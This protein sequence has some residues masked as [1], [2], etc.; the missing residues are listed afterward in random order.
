MMVT[1]AFCG[2][3]VWWHRVRYNVTR[4]VLLLAITEAKKTTQTAAMEVHLGLPPFHVMIKAKAKAQA[5]IYRLMCNHQPK[6]KGTDF[7]HIKKILG[8]EHETIPQT[9]SDRSIP[10]YVQD[11]PF[12]IK[13]LKKHKW[14]N[15]F[16]QLITVYRRVQYH[17]MHWC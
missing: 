8:L 11:K 13:F 1:P 10:R 12:K 4:I 15:R 9:G 7:G 17:C 6:L 2:S 16:T 5:A 14:Q 3:T